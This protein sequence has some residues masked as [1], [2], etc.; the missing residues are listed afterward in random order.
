MTINPENIQNKGSLETEKKQR[1]G[2][3]P[4]SEKNLK[5]FKPGQSGNPSGRPKG[6][7]LTR[8][9]EKALEDNDGERADR[10]IDAL[11]DQACAGKHPQIQEIFNRIEG[12]VADRIAGH[13]GGE[14]GIKIE[15]VQDNGD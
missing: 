13:D 1:S 2:L 12:K 10:L 4:N 6:Q 14:L 8:R 3:H 11:I 9:L 15:F 7:S 5:K